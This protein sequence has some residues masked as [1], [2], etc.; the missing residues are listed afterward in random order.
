MPFSDDNARRA[1]IFISYSS[2]EWERKD[3]LVDNLRLG[4]AGEWDIWDDRKIRAGDNWFEEIEKALNRAE[5]A[6]LLVS[7]PFLKSEFIQ[8]TEVADLLQAQR[9]RGLRIVPIL[10]EDCPYQRFQWIKDLQF[11]LKIDGKLRAVVQPNIDDAG[12][13]ANWTA[14]V[15]EIWQLIDEASAQA[16][17]DRL[18]G[19][20]VRRLRDATF[21]EYR[22][23][24]RS[25]KAIWCGRQTPRCSRGRPQRTFSA[26]WSRSGNAIRS[27]RRQC[28]CAL[29]RECSTRRSSARSEATTMTTAHV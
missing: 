4:V 21:A 17:A 13:Q 25:T 5:M 16:T 29:F 20:F 15:R 10:L 9:R 8:R 1:N 24:R 26:S 3:Q 28:G 19:H 11:A 6:I 14:V 23:R 18:A 22:G 7:M 12:I 2:I 27:L